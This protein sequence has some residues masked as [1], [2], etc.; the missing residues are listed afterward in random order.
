MRWRT[1]SWVRPPSSLL[2]RSPRWE[3]RLARR[4]RPPLAGRTVVVTRAGERATELTD[5]L[6]RAGAT[7]L[8]LPLTHQ[9]DA[10]DGGDALRAAAVRVR[11][12]AWVV[13]TS[14]NAAER[15]MGA[16][17]DAR[18]LGG[19]A[20][21]AVGPATAERVATGRRRARS[22]SGRAQR[23]GAGGRIPGR[24]AAGSGWV[25]FPCGDLAPPTIAEGLGEK[26]WAVRRVEAYRT[27]P[28]PAPG[29]ALLRQIGTA[30]AVTFAAASAVHAFVGL[31]N[32]IGEP[33]TPPPYVVCIGPTTAAAA[34]AAGLGG[35]HE[36]SA[37]SARGIVDELIAGVGS[38]GWG[39]DGGDG[40]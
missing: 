9:V 26:G 35:V 38:D 19:V 32:P 23:A 36:A 24:P 28:R 31:R 33:V 6:E 20:V 21:A 8:S 29:A 13:L 16:L 40:P 3:A 11:E 27:V 7:V 17:R 4:C 1:S 22:G 2:A 15:L 18:D 34:R 14:V 10:T 30:D 25:L 39:S 12:N 37:P 5:A